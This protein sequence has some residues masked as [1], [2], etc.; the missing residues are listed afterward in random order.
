MSCSRPAR[1]TAWSSQTTTRITTAPPRRAR[2]PDRGRIAPGARPP[3]CAARSSTSASPI[4]PSSRPPPPGLLVEPGAVVLHAQAGPPVGD[5]G[6]DRHVRRARVLAGVAKPLARGAVEQVLDRP[7]QGEG[8]RDVHLDRDAPRL[9]GRRQVGDRR[10]EALVLQTAGVDVHDG[11][12]EAPRALAGRVGAVAQRPHR[13]LV[14]AR[15]RPPGGGGQREREPREVLDRPVVQVGGHPPALERR[16]LEG[17]LQQPFAF[18]QAVA[19]APRGGPGQRQLDQPQQHQ[20]PGRPPAA[21]PP[22]CHGRWRRW[23][24]RAGRART[25]PGGPPACGSAGTP[26]GAIPRRARTRSRA[27]RGR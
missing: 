25:A 14:G 12:P 23:R 24:S 15:G 27:R 18:P 9:Q 13:R 19:K 7:R 6:G 2:F 16:R 10:R 17:G 20:R 5:A 8:G 21:P 4:W 22:R 26:P 1:T 11:R 3:R